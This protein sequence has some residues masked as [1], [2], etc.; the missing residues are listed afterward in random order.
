MHLIREKEMTQTTV[1]IFLFAKVDISF[2]KH[3]DK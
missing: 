2:D 1:V 3:L